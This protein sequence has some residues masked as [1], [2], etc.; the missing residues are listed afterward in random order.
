MQLLIVIS[1]DLLYFYGISSD[2]SSFISDI[3]YL[4]SLGSLAKGLP[5]LLSLQ[6]LFVNVF[7]SSDF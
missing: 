4:I 2:V 7:F 3:I 5:I 6:K 1:Y